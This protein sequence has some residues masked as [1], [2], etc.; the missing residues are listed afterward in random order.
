[1]SVELSAEATLENK[2]VDAQLYFPP[3]FDLDVPCSKEAKEKKQE[4][5]WH[6][7]QCAP[8]VQRRK[9]ELWVGHASYQE[10]DEPRRG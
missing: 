3:A 10:E 6:R 2:R 8:L 5:K 1:M 7:Q 9:I 4:M